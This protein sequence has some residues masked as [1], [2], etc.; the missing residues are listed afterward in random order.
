MY[1]LVT[2][3]IRYALLT[4][5][6][7]AID[8]LTGHLWRNSYYPLSKLTTTWQNHRNIC[9]PFLNESPSEAISV[10]YA[11]RTLPARAENPA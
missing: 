2:P 9:F 10:N 11:L 1:I 3:I 4:R 6:R 8:L 7:W 5:I